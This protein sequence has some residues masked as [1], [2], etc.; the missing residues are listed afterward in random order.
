MLFLHYLGLLDFSE[1]N[2]GGAWKLS[3][4]VHL[5]K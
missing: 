1:I 4:Q 3:W 2:E 5:K